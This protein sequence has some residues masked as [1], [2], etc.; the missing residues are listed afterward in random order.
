MVPRQVQVRCLNRVTEDGL[1]GKNR[2]AQT[3]RFA[4]LCPL[5]AE[6]GLLHFRPTERLAAQHD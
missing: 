4:K 6:T 5:A 1:S 2:C 3:P